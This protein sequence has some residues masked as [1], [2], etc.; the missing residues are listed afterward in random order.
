VHLRGKTVV[1][2]QAND[3]RH[4]PKPGVVEEGRPDVA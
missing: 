3:L 1:T 2:R 4:R